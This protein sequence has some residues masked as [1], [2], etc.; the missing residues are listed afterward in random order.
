MEGHDK[1]FKI[2]KVFTVISKTN[3]L[4]EDAKEVLLPAKA[5]VLFSHTQLLILI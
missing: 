2:P 5:V 1:Q 3:Q 4:P